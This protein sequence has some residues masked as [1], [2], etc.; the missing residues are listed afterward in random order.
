MRGKN[1]NKDKC[2]L[3]G[4]ADTTQTFH[5]LVPKKL[6]K[7][8]VIVDLFPDVDLNAYGIMV[9]SPCHK[10]IHKKINHLDLA[11]EYYS[12][13]KLKTHLELSKFIAFQQKSHKNKRIK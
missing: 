13:E 2:E 10:M 3:C 7:K 9:C 6:H 5:H 4:R 12:L 1:K 11:T 8:N